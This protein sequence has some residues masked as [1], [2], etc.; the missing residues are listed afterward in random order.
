MSSR[1]ADCKRTIATCQDQHNG[2]QDVR[3]V[4]REHGFAATLFYFLFLDLAIPLD[5]LDCPHDH[6]GAHVRPKVLRP[7]RLRD[8]LP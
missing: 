3:T 8:L 5:H 4:W 6:T 7:L 2:M 1:P